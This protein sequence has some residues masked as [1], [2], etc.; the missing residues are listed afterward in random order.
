MFMAYFEHKGCVQ[1]NLYLNCVSQYEGFEK[2]SY[3][4][5]SSACNRRRHWPECVRH[6]NRT[7]CFTGM[8]YRAQLLKGRLVLNPGFFFLLQKQ[9]FG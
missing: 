5:V 6:V 3:R 9:F 2:I 8:S 1:R 4:S 7:F